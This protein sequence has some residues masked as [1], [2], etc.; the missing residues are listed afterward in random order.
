[1]PYNMVIIYYKVIDDNQAYD[2]KLFA[3]SNNIE[4]YCF[5]GDPS[6]LS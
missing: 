6:D 3:H 2:F 1:M 4:Q 5:I